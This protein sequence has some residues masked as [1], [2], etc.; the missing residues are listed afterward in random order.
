MTLQGL[1]GTKRVEGMTLQG[2]EGTKRVE[3]MTSY[4]ADVLFRLFTKAPEQ[5]IVMSHYCVHLKQL[6]AWNDVQIIYR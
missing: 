1:E 6:K 4:L 2:L 5:Q 3:G